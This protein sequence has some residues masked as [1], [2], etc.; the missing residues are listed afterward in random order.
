MHGQHAVANRQRAAEGLGVRGA[1][2]RTAAVG[3]MVAVV[4]RAGD[5]MAGEPRACNDTGAGTEAGTKPEERSGVGC[6]RPRPAEAV[7]RSVEPPARTGSRWAGTGGTRGAGG[8]TAG[9]LRELGPCN[10]GHTAAGGTAWDGEGSGGCDDMTTATMPGP[11]AVIL[12]SGRPPTPRSASMHSGL[13][14]AS[15]R[16]VYSANERQ[17]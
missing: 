14:S 2:R 10:V 13:P 4:C 9:A 5:A 3:V 11:Y 12:E 7:R 16:N 15:M 6:G 17:E 8:R 1:G